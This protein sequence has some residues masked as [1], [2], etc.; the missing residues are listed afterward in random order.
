MG[1]SENDF[2]INRFS[3]QI[4]RNYYYTPITTINV[5]WSELHITTFIFTVSP[6]MWCALSIAKKWH[7]AATSCLNLL[8][9]SKYFHNLSRLPLLK[10]GPSQLGKFAFK[11]CSECHLRAHISKKNDQN[12]IVSSDLP[13]MIMPICQ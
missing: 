4:V 13:I 8:H 1:I 7:S 2:K 5:I 3:K 11:L 12:K 6:I 10:W 9:Y